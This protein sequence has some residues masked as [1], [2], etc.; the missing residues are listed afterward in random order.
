MPA[1]DRSSSSPAARPPHP[2]TVP[3]G[4]AV[5]P[6]MAKQAPGPHPATVPRGSAA[7]PK[8]TKA[9]SG[10]H[11]A[12]LPRSSAVQPK[13]AKP[14]PGPHPA[15]ITRPRSAQAAIQRSK[16]QKKRNKIPYELKSVGSSKQMCWQV[17]STFGLDDERIV[18]LFLENPQTKNT[19]YS[20]HILRKGEDPEKI[21]KLRNSLKKKDYES[22]QEG[23]DFGISVTD[24]GVPASTVI[25]LSS[26]VE[27]DWIIFDICKALVEAKASGG[28]FTALNTQDH[29]AVKF[30]AE[31]VSTINTRT[32]Q[33]SS[34]VGV[35]VGGQLTKTKGTDEWTF[36]VN[37]CGSMIEE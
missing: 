17:T 4:S 7:Q 6:K 16:E 3:R 23:F 8:M 1:D 27:F 36:E 33:I 24:S 26:G 37:H 13:M 32:Q 35:E 22:V 5:Q 10:P 20:K 18:T 28:K 9:A 31:C 29:V 34:G 21:L 12:T 2:A 11:P 19:F 30:G 14:A 25:H 15:M